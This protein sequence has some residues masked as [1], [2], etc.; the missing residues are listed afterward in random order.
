[1]NRLYHKNNKENTHIKITLKK[2]KNNNTIIWN[3]KKK[4]N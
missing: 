2:Y 4:N 1:M 3:H